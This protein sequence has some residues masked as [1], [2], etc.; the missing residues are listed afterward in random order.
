MIQSCFRVRFFR[1]L[2][3]G[4]GLLAAC[5]VGYVSR[6]PARAASAPAAVDATAE[7]IAA[8]DQAIARGD[9]EALK[10]VLDA[11]PS[12][13]HGEPGG[14]LSPL[15]QSILRRQTKIVHVLLERGADV[16]VP[17]SSS[18]TPLHLA[19][20]RGDAGIVGELL[21]RKADPTKRDRIGWTPLHHAAAKNRMEI[22]TLLL[23][24]GMDPNLRS[25]LGGTALHEAAASGVVEMVN[26]LLARGIDP[27]VRSK[28][29]VTALDLAREY[30]HPEVVAILEKKK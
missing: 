20:E 29:G 14:K 25:E 10:Q 15:H 18:R 7:E 27:A 13:L 19:V 17:D 24:S 26:L 11:K 2:R 3:A 8:R 22:A 23:D 6:T 4:L 12:L 30:K 9:V 5:A 1:A 28:P 21:R 16:Q